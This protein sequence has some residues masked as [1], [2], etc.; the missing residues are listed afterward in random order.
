MRGLIKVFI[1]N[2]TELSQIVDK[3]SFKYISKHSQ[4]SKLIHPDLNVHSS[5]LI[6]SCVKKRLDLTHSKVYYDQNFEGAMS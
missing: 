3:F 1:S 6:K 2:A 4:I 5:C